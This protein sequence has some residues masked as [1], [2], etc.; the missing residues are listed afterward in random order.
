M[1][2]CRGSAR[3]PSSWIR[4]TVAAIPDS[5]IS[6]THHA[7]PSR[8]NRRAIAW[9]QPPLP[10]PVTIAT[11]PL[12]VM[13]VLVEVL[14]IQ[15]RLNISPAQRP[16]TCLTVSPLRLILGRSAPP[17]DANTHQSIDLSRASF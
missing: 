9:P 7:A 12:I 5:E 1:S 13:V 4:A 6:E 8:A 2:A 14:E 16:S 17:A 11:F 15:R 3:P 10:A